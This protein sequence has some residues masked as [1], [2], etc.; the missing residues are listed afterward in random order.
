MEPTSAPTESPTALPTAAPVRLA[1]E[2][3]SP[4]DTPEKLDLYQQTL[5]AIYKDKLN[6]P[7]GMDAKD[8]IIVTDANGDPF[9]TT[10]GRG[11]TLK[12]EYEIDGAC[13]TEGTT[14]R[15]FT[16]IMVSEMNSGGTS[17]VASNLGETSAKLTG[18]I[19]CPDGSIALEGDACP[20]EEEANASASLPIIPIAAGGGG[21]LL[22]IVVFL[23]VRA[24]KKKGASANKKSKYTIAGGKPDAAK[25]T[26]KAT[27][28]GSVTSRGQRTSRGAR[29][30]RASAPAPPVRS[31]LSPMGGAAF[32]K[33]TGAKPLISKKGSMSPRTLAT[34]A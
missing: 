10:S 26:G 28:R 29:T 16:K 5:A 30:G 27:A 18:S 14:A 19:D 33:L 3:K 22:L 34:E 11:G 12:F 31:T 15:D 2:V 13:N 20:I 21:L 25:P 8:C 32:P 23:V 7:A 4:P 24:K 9:R 6:P 17:R 1:L